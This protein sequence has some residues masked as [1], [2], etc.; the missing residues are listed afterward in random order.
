M[1]NYSFARFAFARLRPSRAGRGPRP[2]ACGAEVY[3]ST[4]SGRL[5]RQ[6]CAMSYDVSTVEYYD[7]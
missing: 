1:N 6:V 5:T 7:S 3:D 4:G 2:W